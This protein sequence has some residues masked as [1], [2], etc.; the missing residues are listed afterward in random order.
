MLCCLTTILFTVYLMRS[1]V[2]TEGV[3]GWASLG[4]LLWGFITVAELVVG[5]GRRM[6]GRSLVLSF[7]LKDTEETNIY[8]LHA[9]ILAM[10]LQMCLQG[11]S[12]VAKQFY[13]KH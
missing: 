12:A 3:A 2:E 8:L 9:T 6:L 1:L 7:H 5:I 11:D 10:S 4:C 13:S